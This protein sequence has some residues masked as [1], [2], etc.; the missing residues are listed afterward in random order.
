MA[1]DSL[2]LLLEQPCKSGNQC[3]VYKKKYKFYL[4]DDGSLF[5]DTCLHGPHRVQFH[6]GR[7]VEVVVGVEKDQGLHLRVHHR[8]RR[9][10]P[11]V[12]LQLIRDI[13]QETIY[14]LSIKKE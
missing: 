10:R 5:L 2:V 9:H 13:L 3:Y 11:V 6:P 4:L 12:V 7:K 1:F 14:I 8:R